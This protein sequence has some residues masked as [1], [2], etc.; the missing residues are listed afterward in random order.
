MTRAE[1]G[2]ATLDIV[3]IP[4]LQVKA[5]AKARTIFAFG[6]GSKEEGISVAVC[7]AADAN[8]ELVIVF[9]CCKIN[10][11]ARPQRGQQQLA[12]KVSLLSS[13]R[14]YTTCT[15]SQW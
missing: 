12:G 5:K 6:V 9:Q 4:F 14:P 7:A 3:T 13:H 2:V 15:S 8:G 10:A 1:L 11:R